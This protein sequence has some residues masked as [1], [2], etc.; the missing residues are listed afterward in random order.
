MTFLFGHGFVVTCD[1]QHM[2]FKGGVVI[3][4]GVTEINAC[5]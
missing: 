2:Q 1:G 5:W 3:D 4:K